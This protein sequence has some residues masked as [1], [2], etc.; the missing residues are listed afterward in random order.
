MYMTN[1]I[2][3]VMKKMPTFFIKFIS[4]FVAL[5]LLITANQ[6][7]ADNNNTKVSPNYERACAK[8]NGLACF[9]LGG[10]FLQGNGMKQDDMKA[11]HFFA[12]A[13]DRKEALG[14]AALGWMHEYGRGFPQN[15]IKA[16]KLYSQ[17]CT[18]GSA[19]SCFLVG[20]MHEEGKGI[21]QDSMQA[22]LFYT[23]GCELGGG[24]YETC[25]PY[26]YKD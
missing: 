14:C 9:N 12:E 8:G 3:F 23:K 2:G 15:F 22:V 18:L 1:I 6:V 24:S 7:L 21:T 17:G 20:Q 11:I 10:K 13:C 5:V 4:Q 26:L 19:D 16:S 25:K